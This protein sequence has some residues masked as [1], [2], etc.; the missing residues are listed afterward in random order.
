MSE[1]ETERS[2]GALIRDGRAFYEACEC[3]NDDQLDERERFGALLA[4]YPG[5]DVLKWIERDEQHQAQRQA[6]L[7]LRHKRRKALEAVVYAARSLVEWEDSGEPHGYRAQVKL[8]R[9]ALG[10]V[11]QAEAKR[12]SSYEAV[13]QEILE[14]TEKRMGTD[15]IDWRS[16]LMLACEEIAFLREKADA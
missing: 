4:N 5:K 13:W 7:R 3:S 1:Q 8:L 6:E 11:V 12:P 15:L 2:L 16:A 10:G 14:R 9:E